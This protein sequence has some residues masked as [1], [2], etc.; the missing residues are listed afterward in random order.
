MRPLFR[1]IFFA[2]SLALAG[3]AADL[4]LGIIGTDTGHAPDF[5]KLLNNPSDPNHVPGA[6]VV[7]A[8]KGGS[9]DIDESRDR[10]EKFASELHEKYQVKIVDKIS[11]M[12]AGVDGILLESL[13]GRPHL[14]Q[15]RE[16]AKCG[17]PVFIDKPLAADIED[18]RE[19]VRAGQASRIPW[20]TASSLRFSEIA[21]LKSADMTGVM[22]WAP[23]P[24]EPH[25]KLDLAWYS[26]HGV[27][28]LYTLMGTG[29]LEVTRTHSGNADVMV[30]RWKD[31]RVGV[32][33]AERP[34]SKYGAVVFKDKTQIAAIPDLQ[35][36]Y[37]GL[38]KEIVKFMQTKTPPFP[39]SE[40][41]EMFEFMDAAQ[42]SKD[43]GGTPALLKQN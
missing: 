24:T 8:Y 43:A 4:R 11:D 37:S 17:K 26:I 19:I 6:K 5:T 13:D 42:R 36:N 18:A 29:C 7:V 14:A 32:L 40:T 28:M 38:V 23:G 25:H 2:A 41:V 22:V 15:F 1:S 35:V 3:Q 31:G 10:V 21:T 30:G 34:Y 27:E 33:H 20:F 9:P 39:T 12:C 16:A